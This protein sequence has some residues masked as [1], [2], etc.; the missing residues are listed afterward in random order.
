[1]HPTAFSVLTSDDTQYDKASIHSPLSS[2]VSKSISF[3]RFAYMS[4]LHTRLLPADDSASGPTTLP[5]TVSPSFTTTPRPRQS[6]LSLL[7]TLR[8]PLLAVAGL[9]VLV[10]VVLTFPSRT[11]HLTA[12]SD[13][14]AAHS[15]HTKATSDNDVNS[16]PATPRGKTAVTEEAERMLHVWQQQAL[17]E[18]QTGTAENSIAAAAVVHDGAAGN[19]LEHVVLQQRNGGQVRSLDDA[20]LQ[21]LRWPTEDETARPPPPPLMTPIRGGTSKRFLKARSG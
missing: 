6:P 5:A 21:S 4:P 10:L 14:A 7:S 18:E 19:E 15:F 11:A 8:I 3:A 20:A 9:V 16:T 13:V 1:M 2:A 12:E 17:A